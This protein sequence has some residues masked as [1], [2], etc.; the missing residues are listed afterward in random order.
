MRTDPYDILGVKPDASAKDIRSAFRK[1]A[2]THHPDLNP[3]DKKAEDAFK[4][5]S[6]AHEILGDEDKRALFD[7]GLIDINGVERAPHVDWE[8]AGADGTDRFRS[9][10]FSGFSAGGGMDD[11]EDIFASFMSRR[12]G[13]GHGPQGFGGFRPGDFQSGDLNAKGNDLR[14][15]MEVDFLDAVNGTTATVTLPDGAALEVKIPAGTRD[16]QVLR[17]RGK[18]SSGLGKGTRGDA[19]IAIGIRPHPLFA[20]DGD[21]IRIDL[22]IS[23]KE[24]VLGG[25]VKVPTPTGSVQMTLKPNSNTGTVL[26]LK[27]KGLSKRDGG[28]GNVGGD[29]GGDIRGDLFVTLKIVLPQEPDA[30]LA[31]FVSRWKA[32]D[33]FDPRHNLAA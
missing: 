2:K 27:G 19:Y 11:F 26:R 23:L 28:N 14:F 8:T 10:G 24:A 5:I 22:P 18:G 1:L 33:G 29:I 3:G 6:L 7:R 4:E 20:Q 32:A 17:L 13:T 21:D 16:G 31:D 30:D 12:G 15:T 25:K 9:S